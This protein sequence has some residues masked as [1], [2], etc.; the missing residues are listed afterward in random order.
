MVDAI[1]KSEALWEDPENIRPIVDDLVKNWVNSLYERKRVSQMVSDILDNRELHEKWET[2]LFQ[3]SKRLQYIISAI[4]VVYAKEVRREVL[5][6]FVPM[7]LTLIN[8]EI[9]QYKIAMKISESTHVINSR[10]NI[11]L[12]RIRS[13]DKKR[14]GKEK[15]K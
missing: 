14:K 13:Q 6:R 15:K 4:R 8:R 11:K 9:Q 7:L 3:L 12:I 2:Q 5:G 1:I 10:T